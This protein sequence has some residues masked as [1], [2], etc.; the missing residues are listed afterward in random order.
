MGLGFIAKRYLFSKKKFNFIT[1][2]SLI[3]II[4]VTI[5]VSFALIIVLSVFNGFM[6]ELREYL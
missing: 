3:S 4:G 1:I 2:I 5:G 6:T